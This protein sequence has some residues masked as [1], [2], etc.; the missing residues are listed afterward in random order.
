MDT[1]AACSGGRNAV[2]LT[3]PVVNGLPGGRLL[4]GLLSQIS[5]NGLLL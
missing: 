3:F 2:K 5:Q 1:E 4:V